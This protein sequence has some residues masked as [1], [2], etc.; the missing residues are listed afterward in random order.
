MK[1]YIIASLLLFFNILF[2][3][4][5]SLEKKILG[6]WNYNISSIIPPESVKENNTRVIITFMN[7][8]N[9]MPKD[10]WLQFKM[11]VKLANFNG[12]P[13]KFQKYNKRA[14]LTLEHTLFVV[15]SASGIAS[16][17]LDA[18]FVIPFCTSAP[19]PPIKLIPS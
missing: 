14:T 3:N 5:L 12:L 2:V 9:G 8:E 16:I 10:G 17:K 13:Q 7:G 1:K 11:T 18:P 6:T 19:K 4:A 15:A